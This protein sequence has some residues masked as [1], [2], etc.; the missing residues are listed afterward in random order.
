VTTIDL[1][2][3]PGAVATPEQLIDFT[4]QWLLNRRLADHTRIAYE[5]EATRWI[6]WCDEQG[7]NPFTLKF[8]H[9]NEFARQLEQLGRKP[10]SVARALSAIS[11]WYDFLIKLEA[12]VANPAA[13]ADRPRIDPLETTTIGFDAAE[14]RALVHAARGDQSLDDECA[15]ALMMFLVQIGARVSEVCGVDLA[16]LG[17]DSGH[18]VV[19]LHMKGR[20]TRRR[21]IP[22][23]LGMAIDALLVARAARSGVQVEEL[24]GR[25]FVDSRDR[26]VVPQRVARFVR[27]AA[28]RAELP[29]AARL[30]PHSFRHGWNTIAAQSGS[31]LETRQRAL[32]HVDPRTTQG[33]DRSRAQLDQDPSYAVAAAVAV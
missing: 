13:H 24:A 21:T 3:I 30:T 14:A 4:R 22:P 26:P 32:A 29:G 33:Y 23:A 7:L 18:R 25:L 2:Q 8:T 9:V 17:W 27:R 16:D 5:R 11:S 15:V 12:I 28:H 20:K 19:V 31:S 1:A 6:R 10:R